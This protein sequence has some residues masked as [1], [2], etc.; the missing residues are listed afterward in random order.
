MP[1]KKYEIRGDYDRETIVVYQ[2]YS[3]DIADPALAKQRFVHPFSLQRMTWIKPS[4]LWLMQRSNWGQKSGQERVLAVRIKRSGW[5]M[6]LSSA[7]LTS[8]EP[9]I[10]RSPEDWTE[11]FK[12]AK[13]H[14]QWDTERSIRGAGLRY[15]SI[16]VGLS[17]HIINEYVQDWIV[18]IEDYT[19]RVRKIYGYLKA[20]QADKAKRQLP[21]ERAY[22][23]DPTIG[24]RLLINR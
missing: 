3:P 11:Q 19:V 1:E 7:V 9:N 23:V 2:A 13:V 8:F 14:V 15:Y 16:Q 24:Q 5:D 21:S 4:F 18:G 22:P 10:Y 20:G 17:R 12:N 6:A